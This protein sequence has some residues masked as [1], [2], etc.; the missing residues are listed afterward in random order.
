MAKV[1]YPWDEPRPRSRAEEQRL[2][3][4]QAMAELVGDQTPVY[5]RADVMELAGLTDA[6]W[7]W[8]VT[9]N[10]FV[11]GTI[12]EGETYRRFSVREVRALRMA[13]RLRRRGVRNHLIKV[14]VN[15]YLNQGP[16]QATL[17]LDGPLD[18]NPPRRAAVAH[19]S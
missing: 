9:Y 19:G 16:E 5:R 12:P 4:L 1:H 7:S 6:D 17:P 3:S 15:Q 13:K 8:A 2:R 18:D 10:R 11:E 14:I